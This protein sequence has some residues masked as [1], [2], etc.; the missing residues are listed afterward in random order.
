MELV[1]LW[2]EPITLSLD[3]VRLEPLSKDHLDDLIIAVNDGQLYNHWYT[4]IPVHKYTDILVYQYT[5]ILVYW[6]NVT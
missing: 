5:C 3:N 1:M 2:L 4:S 6:Y